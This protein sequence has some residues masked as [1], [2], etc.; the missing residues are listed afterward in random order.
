MKDIAQTKYNEQR[1]TRSASR[2]WTCAS[3]GSICRR[4]TSLSVY[5]RMKA[6][7]R[8]EA[9]EF[10]AQGRAAA[11]KIRAT[12]EREATIIKAEDIPQVGAAQG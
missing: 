1:A 4:R 10:R 9:E 3:R 11:N 7:R 6:A 2:S 5:E 12:A 8:Q